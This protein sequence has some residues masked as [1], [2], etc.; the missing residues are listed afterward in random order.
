[1]KAD[2]GSPHSIFQN[3][4]LMMITPENWEGLKNLSHNSWCTSKTLISHCSH[5]SVILLTLQ[6]LSLYFRFCS[7][8]MHEL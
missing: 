3:T 5:I 6:K 1:M 7:V 4:V 2:T 8:Y